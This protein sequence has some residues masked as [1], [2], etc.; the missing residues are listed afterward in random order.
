LFQIEARNISKEYFM[1]RTGEQVLALKDISFSFPAGKF[2]CIVGPSGCGKTTLLNIIAGLLKPSQGE[3]LQNGIPIVGPAKERAMVFQ[4]AALLPWRTVMRNVTYGLEIQGRSV[5][6]AKK[7]AQELINLVDLRGFEES[8]P[9]E[10]SGGMQQRVNLARALAINPQLLLMDEPFASLDTQ[11]REFM[12]LEI[13]RIWSKTG[14]TTFFVTHS[15]DEAIFLADEIILLTARPGQIR[16]SVPVDLARPRSPA[17][18]K[19][20][21]YHRLQDSLHDLIDQEFTQA[22]QLDLVGRETRP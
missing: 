13:E 8:Y 5:R 3:I 21:D 10:L 6:D 2:V 20:A 18:K 7:T 15:I 12:Q 1:R 19:S 17:T 14:Q 16:A 22:I 4:S 9:R 11:T